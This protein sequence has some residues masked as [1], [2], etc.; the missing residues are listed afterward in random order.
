MGGNALGRCFLTSCPGQPMV[1]GEVS[2]LQPR[3]SAANDPEQ[4][5]SPF[6][7]GQVVAQT[8]A[9]RLQPLCPLI[10]LRLS[11]PRQR[12]QWLCP[13]QLVNGASPG[14]KRPGKNPRSGDGLRSKWRNRRGELGLRQWE[15]QVISQR[16]VGPGPMGA[17][18]DDILE[19]PGLP[20]L[21]RP[22]TGSTALQPC[23]QLNLL[24]RSL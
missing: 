2:R 8:R 3:S 10:S 5:T 22:P 13:L 18:Q 6:R 4:V 17:G 24:A 12:I 15:V 23:H 14:S 21:G 9:S 11:F 1:P 20:V 7:E 16:E 19:C